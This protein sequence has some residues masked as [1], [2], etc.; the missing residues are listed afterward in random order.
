MNSVYFSHD[1]FYRRTRKRETER[2]EGE[3]ERKT[4]EQMIA[5]VLEVLLAVN[6]AILSDREREEGTTQNPMDTFFC[7]INLSK[8]KWDSG[9]KLLAIKLNRISHTA[10]SFRLLLT[11]V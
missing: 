8:A 1:Q 2:G 11:Y 4:T 6:V 3:R 5:Y 10:E 7:A 9:L